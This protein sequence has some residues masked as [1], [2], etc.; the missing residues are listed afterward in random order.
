MRGLNYNSE[1]KQYRIQFN[2]RHT[3][4]GKRYR[5]RLPAGTTRREAERYLAKL[6]E[7]DRLEQLVWP[8]DKR[9]SKEQEKPWTLGTFASEIYLPLMEADNR[10]STIKRK[11]QAIRKLAFWFWDMPLSEITAADVA[12]FAA[13]RKADRVSA[14]TVNLEI[15]ELR[16]ILNVAHDNGFLPHP[17][18]RFRTLSEKDKRPVRVLTDAEF[19]QALDN[20]TNK[21]HVFRALTLFLRYMGT[22]WTETRNLRRDRI[23]WQTGRIVFDGTDTKTGASRILQAP[24]GLLAEL[25]QIP[26]LGDF[27]FMHEHRG[28]PYQMPRDGR[29]GGD[30]RAAYPWQGGDEN[31]KFGPH[32]YRHTFA[33]DCLR[34]GVGLKTV[35]VWLGHSSIKVTADLYGHVVPMDH[36]AEIGALY[37]DQPL[38]RVIGEE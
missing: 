27:V 36:A 17:P 3:Q 34:R 9:Q 25:R 14:R 28:Q 2:S 30:N 33:T 20:A 8:S 26:N 7:D 21:G 18:P 11:E 23:D 4:P 16:H 13:E 5:E 29:F 31:M 32:V 6:R 38:L 19:D 37:P 12:Q 35:Q 10:A 24:P 1:T 22:R 15:G